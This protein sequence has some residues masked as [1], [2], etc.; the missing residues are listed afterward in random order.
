MKR[1]P[2][3]FAARHGPWVLVAGL[4]A[5]LALPSLAGELAPLIPYLVIALMYLAVLR[6]GPK[7]L[8]G[9][10]SDLPRA[11]GVALILQLGLPLAVIGAAFAGGWADSPLALALVVMAAA[12]SIASSPNL[13]LMMGRSPLY[14]MGLLVAGTAL[15]PV[16]I[17]P[18][19]WLMPKLGSVDVVLGAALKLF[20]TIALSVLAAAATRALFLRRPSP[21]TFAR[22]DGASALVLAVFVVAL[23]PAVSAAAASTPLTALAWLG[24]ALCANLGLQFAFFRLTGP[25][26]TADVATAISL[27]AGNRNMALFLVALP[28]DVMAP[29]MV[30]VG[31]Y[32]IP[33][34]LT[35]LVMRR[36]Y[37]PRP[38]KGF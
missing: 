8:M 24:A 19:F 28:P 32:Q 10:V 30:F 17:M 23:M 11:A 34:Y 29:I 37:H 4:C 35:P 1:D 36:F 27:I 5:G 7:N 21:E 26:T 33:M 12:P 9:A 20:A 31:C 14:A 15:L 2:L 22:L 16:T 18:V 25:R 3:I 6:I 13:C 38:D